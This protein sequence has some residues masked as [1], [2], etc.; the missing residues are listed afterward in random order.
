MRTQSCDNHLVT[1]ASSDE[2]VATVDQQGLVTGIGPGT[3]TITA[4][5]AS[6]V[7]AS[8]AVTVKEMDYLYLPAGLERIEDEAFYGAFCEA[9]IIPDGC[10][11]IGHLAFANCSRLVY[12]RIPASVTEIAEDAFD[13]CGAE[14]VIDRRSN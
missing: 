11:S 14:L 3:A 12:I 5:A 7:S 10:R 9:V 1:F 13:G 4:T 8:C 2:S 6:G